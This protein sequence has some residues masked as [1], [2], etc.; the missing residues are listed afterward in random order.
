MKLSALPILCSA[1]LSSA[2]FAAEWPEWRGPG[3][4]GQS[5]EIGL[6]VEWGD[7]T[8]IAWK[9]ELPGRGWSSPV[10]D[11]KQVWMTTAIETMAKPEDAERR[12]KAN[13]GNQPLVLLEKVEFLAICVD[14]D[15]GKI[16]KTVSLLTVPEPQWVHKLNS[17]ASPTPVIDDGKLYCHFGALGNACADMKTGKVI[18]TNTE[19]KVMHENG[20][21]GS[22][23]VWKDKVIF[24][25]DGSDE[26]YIAALDKKTGKLAWKTARSGEM[27][28]DPQL[29]KS[30]GTPLV[31]KVNGKEQLLSPSTDWLY[32]YD[33]KGKELWKVKY[34]NLGFSL[35]PR[36]VVGHGMVFMSTGFMRA[37]MLAIRYDSAAEPEIVWRYTKGAPTMPS[38]VLVGN[39]LYFVNDGGM[40]TCLDAISGKEH[41][42]ERLGGNY[43]S[44][45]TFADGRI[46]VSS[47]EGLT[48]V[49]KPGIK[50]EVLA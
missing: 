42:R 8:N 5:A 22:P 25:L 43:S 11:G 10:I 28:A 33:D 26:Q 9:V 37:E 30:Y 3:G 17:Y 39:E 44:S 40:L 35:T 23:V 31:L 49:V 29:R 1:L 18:W 21:G 7:G 24:Q 36:P 27:K 2:A 19:L 4:L 13:T 46:Y 12:L 45:P 48:T 38:P 41:Y 34:G 20:P 50:F 16:I 6:P 15:S 47:R 14:R 32:S